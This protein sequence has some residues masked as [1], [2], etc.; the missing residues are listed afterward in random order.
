MSGFGFSPSDVVKA[1]DLV[2][3]ARR[4]LR[5]VGGAKDDFQICMIFLCGL[6]QTLKS[7]REH[8]EK[9]QDS[10]QVAIMAHVANIVEKHLSEKLDGLESLD[11]T[12][13]GLH[14]RSTAST[15]TSK[16][17]WAL[18]LAQEVEKM[19]KKIMLPLLIVNINLASL[20]L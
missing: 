9:M 20:S 6:E 8:A 13:G 17:K 7:V 11:K 18:H 2:V 19:Q 5:D 4:A 1:I 12:L 10:T 15:V 16:L 14:A 3:K